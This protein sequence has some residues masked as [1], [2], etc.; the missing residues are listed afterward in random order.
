VEENPKMILTKNNVGVLFAGAVAL[1]LF[2]CGES[3]IGGTGAGTGPGNFEQPPEVTEVSVEEYDQYLEAADDWAAQQPHLMAPWASL[4]TAEQTAAAVVTPTSVAFPATEAMRQFEVGDIL[5]SSN[6]DA[7]KVFL[8]RIVSIQDVGGQITFTTENAAINEVVLQGDL[9]DM[10]TATNPRLIEGAGDFQTMT[11]Q[12]GL[13]SVFPSISTLNDSPEDEGGLAT[14]APSGFQYKIEPVVEGPSLSAPNAG[15]ELDARISSSWWD[16]LV[17]AESTVQVG[18]APGGTARYSTRTSCGAVTGALEFVK[19]R[20]RDQTACKS[21]YDAWIDSP[22]YPAIPRSALGN[23]VRQVNVGGV[24]R[25]VCN[26]VDGGFAYFDADV[27]MPYPEEVAWA[28]N[29]CNGVL[30]RFDMDARFDPRFGLSK[31][32]LKFE[33]SWGREA[34]PSTFTKER[35]SFLSRDTYKIFWIG[36]F[37][38]VLRLEG[39]IIANFWKI[40]A[41]GEVE[42]GFDNIEAGIDA[43]LNLHYNGGELTSASSWTANSRV[44]PVLNGDWFFEGSVQGSVERDFVG[45]EGG[46]YFYDLLGPYLIPASLYG[47]VDGAVG[48]STAGTSFC[49]F[50]ITGGVKGEVGV[51]G[52]VPFTSYQADWKL[53][54]YDSCG[55]GDRTREAFYEQ[56]TNFC[57]KHCIN[58][59]PLE[60]VLEWDQVTDLDLAVIDPE[61]NR[62]SYS[63]PNRNGGVHTN[64]NGCLDDNCEEGGNSEKVV[65]GN[66]PASGE[67]RIVVTNFSG[68]ASA[69]FT[70]KV[71]AQRQNGE[72]YLDEEFSGTAPAEARSEETFSF[73]FEPQR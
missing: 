70:V 26:D 1:A 3:T 43:T 58:S 57:L 72:L 32:H 31:A 61:G 65:W 13:G 29:T 47:R 12:I 15:M 37:P 39:K 24:P 66:A 44:S 7:G 11:Q 38:V 53:W 71:K 73:N 4:L 52:R 51:R 45:V 19:G 35:D 6:V 62:I 63:A 25:M 8:R 46:V 22:G 50:G 21:A 5:V 36:W 48:V 30:E 20:D 27:Y 2:G 33:G 59:Q 28:R 60:V 69:P 9:S 54:D 16:R 10:P 56:D 68:T 55:S 49:N 23:G 18:A 34:L 14:A 67:Y 17:D 40:G 64:S 42:V 41:K